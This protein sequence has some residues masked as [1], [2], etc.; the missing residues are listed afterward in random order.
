MPPLHFKISQNDI[1]G[2]ACDDLSDR[3]YSSPTPFCVRLSRAHSS[4]I[5]NKV[6]YMRTGNLAVC[7]PQ[8]AAGVNCFFGVYPSL[9]GGNLASG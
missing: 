9:A 3:K 2:Y 8:F 7:L 4:D 5:Q 1:S 6:I